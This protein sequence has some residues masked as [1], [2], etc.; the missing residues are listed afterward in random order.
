MR[1]WSDWDSP[2]SVARRHEKAG[3]RRIAEAADWPEAVRF[4]LAVL[5]TG[6]ERDYFA[7]I[8]MA[9]PTSLLGL[10]R[11]RNTLENS[12]TLC[13]ST[14]SAIRPSTTSTSHVA[15]PTSPSCSLECS[16]A[17]PVR[18]YLATLRR[19][20]SSSALETGRSP[21]TIGGLCPLLTRWT[22]L[23]ELDSASQWRRDGHRPVGGRRCVTP[24]AS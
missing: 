23:S 1:C 19:Y 8:R 15:S 2:R 3:G 5:G 20:E 14:N 24:V 9:Q 17:R 22:C 12:L 11:W 13:T 4:V 16:I 21:R 6:A 18:K 7:G 10:A